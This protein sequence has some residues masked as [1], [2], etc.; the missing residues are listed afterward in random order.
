MDKFV[1]TFQKVF[2]NLDAA[3]AHADDEIYPGADG[4]LYGAG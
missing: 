4:K 2:A 1:E 3:I